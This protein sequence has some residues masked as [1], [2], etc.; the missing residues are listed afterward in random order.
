MRILLWPSLSFPNIGGLE[1]I[2]HAIALQFK[3][4]GHDVIV[5]S[6]NPTCHNFLILNIDNIKIFLFPFISA[7]FKY[8]LSLIKKIL[9][10]VNRIV[11]EF[12][13]NVINVHGWH[14]CIA[15]YQIRLLE[16]KNIP[17]LLTIHGLLEQNYYKTQA[18]LA[19]LRAAKAVNTVSQALV[20]DIMKIQQFHCV[21]LIYNA[22]PKKNLEIQPLIIQPPKLLMIGRLSLEKGFDIAFYAIHQL[23]KKYPE[24]RLTLVGGG[25]QF[26]ALHALKIQLGLERNITMTDFVPPNKI[27][28][29]I[30][31]STLILM[32]SH[33]ESFGLVAIEAMMRGRP[34]I[35]NKVGGLTETIRHNE[36]GLLLEPNTPE[37]WAKA[38][39]DLLRHPARIHA[40]GDQAEKNISSLFAI[41]KTTDQYLNLYQEIMEA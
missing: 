10:E 20:K 29:H 30:D 26:G 17:F 14:E 19:L 31:E 40:M 27:Y 37:N 28:T 7:L 5:I 23:I 12:S 24:L 39:D 13:P 22:L 4:N 41:E 15:Y 32:P 21:K 16:K 36:T 11:D 18:C 6:N 2:T 3:K 25:P 1:V 9:L 33:Y 35:A 34:V 38:I 8:D